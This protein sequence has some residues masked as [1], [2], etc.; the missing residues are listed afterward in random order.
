MPGKESLAAAIAPA[1]SSAIYFVAKGDG[2]SSFSE[3]LVE[4]N[5]AV[6][7]YQLGK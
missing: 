6:R 4:H 5:R 2:R 7:Q 3:T 1:K